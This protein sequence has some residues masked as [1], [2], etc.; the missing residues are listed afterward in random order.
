MQHRE[1][2]SRRR[3]P[4][5]IA[6][7][8]ATR[9]ARGHRPHPVAHASRPAAAVRRSRRRRPIVSPP[10]DGPRTTSADV[11]IAVP[12]ATGAIAAAAAHDR[13]SAEVIRTTRSATSRTVSTA[14][15]AR[16]G[17]SQITVAPPR[18]P[19]SITAP[20]GRGIDVVAGATARQHADPVSCG[21]ASRNAGVAEPTALQRQVGPAQAGARPRCPASG[22]CRHPTGR[23]RRAAHRAA[24]APTR[25]RRPRHPRRRGR[26]SRRRP[27]RD[28]PRRGTRRRRRTARPSTRRHARAA[29]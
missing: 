12:P 4:V 5:V 18:L 26:R 10:G 7:A 22:R 3:R 20:S 9:R 2:A 29:S 17:R 6:A 28:D 24:T 27:R 21:S 14:A 23:R 1:H 8:V 13:T 25:S 19:A 15:V 11:R 16:R